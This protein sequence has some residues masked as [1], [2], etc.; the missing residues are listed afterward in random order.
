MLPAERA[1]DVV[2]RLLPV[3]QRDLTPHHYTLYTDFFCGSS[4]RPVPVKQVV[5][6]LKTGRGV[7]PKPID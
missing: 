2:A 3:R 5:T 4:K 7:N 1:L 6:A